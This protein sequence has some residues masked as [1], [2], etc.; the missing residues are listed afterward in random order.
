M[1]CPRAVA[2]LDLGGDAT[3]ASIWHMK[4][5]T[6]YLDADLELRLKRETRRQRRPMADL[7]REAIRRYVDETPS[8]KPPGGGAFSSK[9]KDTAAQAEETLRATRF[10]ED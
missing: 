7:V 9:R 10:G 6:L 3:Y 5:T 2:V 8:R 1:K 4:R